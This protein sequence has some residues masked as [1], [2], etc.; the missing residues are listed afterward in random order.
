ML[1]CLH[2]VPGIC[3]PAPLRCIRLFPMTEKELPDEWIY[4]ST[5]ALS[6]G[7]LILLKFQLYGW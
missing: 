2:R 1:L 6:N 3:H 5:W 4:S 7:G